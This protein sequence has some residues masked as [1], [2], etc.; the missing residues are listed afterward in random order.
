M[1]DRTLILH[2]P[3]NRAIWGIVC[4]DAYIMYELSG[5]VRFACDDVPYMMA[6]ERVNN[7]WQR[8]VDGN[9]IFEYTDPHTMFV[10]FYTREDIA[11]DGALAMADYIGCKLEFE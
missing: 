11:L 1:I 10:G 5:A 6:S 9:P 8:M 3:K 7:L 2:K 4:T